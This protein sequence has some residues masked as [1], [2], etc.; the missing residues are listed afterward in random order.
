MHAA[1]LQHAPQPLGASTEPRCA[2]TLNAMQNGEWVTT[3]ICDTNTTMRH[4][5]CTAEGQVWRPRDGCSLRLFNGTDACEL[6][7]ANG[8]LIILGDSIQRH[9]YQGLINV[10]S[11]DYELGSLASSHHDEHREILPA[12][13]HDKAPSPLLPGTHEQENETTAAT[14]QPLD[15]CTGEA[16]Y[17]EKSCR[18]PRDLDRQPLPGCGGSDVAQLLQLWQVRSWWEGALGW[19]AKVR[20]VRDRGGTIVAGGGIHDG[21][22]SSKY[23]RVL[24][25][26][27]T[28]VLT[29]PPCNEHARNEH[30][31]SHHDTSNS[32]SSAQ[33]CP[34]VIWM[35]MHSQL[36]SLKPE[37]YREDQS[38]QV[39]L[40]FNAEM[41]RNA[42][43]ET[44][45]LHGALKVFDTFNVTSG[46]RSFDGTHHGRAVSVLKAQLLLNLIDESRR[47]KRGVSRGRVQRL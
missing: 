41:A 44:T 40:S 34:M 31:A 36:E 23:G 30:A 46:A 28:Q 16:Q 6:L 13:H 4:P 22:D 26:L 24:H 45:R 17:D 7:R 10:L 19:V 33:R 25:H 47:P 29:H 38:N 18:F 35:S 43:D 14:L 9:F 27:A 20:R 1:L 3:T 5:M 12:H 39:V 37:Q 42:A 21:F 2:S 15:E 8:G 11:E 32:T